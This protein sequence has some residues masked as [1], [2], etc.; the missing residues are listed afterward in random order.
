VIFDVGAHHGE[1]AKLLRELDYDGR[2]VSFEP[3]SETYAVLTAAMLRDRDWRELNFALGA[4]PGRFPINVTGA[5]DQSSFLAPSA[6]GAIWF[7]GASA[8][9][10]T[11]TVTVKRLDDVICTCIDGVRNPRIYLKL[12]TQGFDN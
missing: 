12:D 8:V 4:K 5:T 11:E 9:S 3:V 7:R 10:R 1:Y 2:I 6:N